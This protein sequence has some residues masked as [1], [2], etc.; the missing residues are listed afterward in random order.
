MSEPTLNTQLNK[1]Q[2]F[3]INFAAMLTINQVIKEAQ[4]QPEQIRKE[5]EK[6]IYDALLLNPAPAEA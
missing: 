6:T 2:Q 5:L 4:H 1:S 3:A